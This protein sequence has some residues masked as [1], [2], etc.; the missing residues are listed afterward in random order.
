[1]E[2]EQ[3]G[4]NGPEEAGGNRPWWRRWRDTDAGQSLVEFSMILPIMLILLFALVD[5]GRAFYTWL[6]VTNGAREGARV[7]ATQVTAAQIQTRVLD[8][9]CDDFSAG[10]CG[11]DETKLTIDITNAQGPRGEAVEV[12]LTYE[13][14]FVTPMGNILAF[15][16]GSNL[17]APTITAHSSMRLE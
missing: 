9:M 4:P 15:I 1:M 2:L 12:D 10:D 16:G 7:G 6:L 14:E 8:S 5:F 11:L 17:S 3:N 13:F